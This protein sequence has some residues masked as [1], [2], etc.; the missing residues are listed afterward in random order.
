[1]QNHYIRRLNELDFL[2]IAGLDAICFPE[3]PWR[4]DDFSSLTDVGG[5]GF[6][7]GHAGIHMGF[8]FA[9]KTDKEVEILRIATIPAF[10]RHGYADKLI[11]EVLKDLEKNTKV[12]LEVRAG[13]EHANKL[14]KKHGFEKIGHREKYYKDPVEDAH[15][16]SKK[17]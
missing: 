7:I 14:Y 6:V 4:A 17:K 11:L 16:F 12:F 1:M 5:F 13:N 2:A 3:S 8:I 10:R 15:V 9:Q